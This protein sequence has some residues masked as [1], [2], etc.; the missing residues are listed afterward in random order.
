MTVW[1]VTSNGGPDADELTP[2]HPSTHIEEV[3]D[4]QAYDHQQPQ[5]E[6]QLQ[7]WL[8]QSQIQWCH[9]NNHR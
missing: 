5:P 3:Y 2:E 8:N 7:L 1:M 6:P 4:N 9:H